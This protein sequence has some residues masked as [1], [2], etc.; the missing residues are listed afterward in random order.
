[1]GQNH[2]DILQKTLKLKNKYKVKADEFIEENKDTNIATLIQDKKCDFFIFRSGYGFFAINEHTMAY[3]IADSVIRHKAG[4]TYLNNCINALL[5]RVKKT[6]LYAKDNS[7]F[8]NVSALVQKCLTAYNNS[9]TITPKEHPAK[10][11]ALTS[12][13]LKRQKQIEEAI[14]RNQRVTTIPSTYSN[15]FSSLYREQIQ[16]RISP[17]DDY[18]YGMSDID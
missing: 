6:K 16:S 17:D 10:A 11:E 18:E 12:K 2:L 3:I 1:M 9:Q 5:A 8:T 14:L 15:S 4:N 13:Q 7:V